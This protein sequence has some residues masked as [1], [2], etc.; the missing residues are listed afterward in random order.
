M[1]D[2]TKPTQPLSKRP[3]SESHITRKIRQQHLATVPEERKDSASPEPDS[4]GREP[5]PS[6]S[7]D[8][9]QESTSH[10]ES[11]NSTKV[12]DREASA[13]PTLSNFP[14]VESIDCA[15]L[16]SHTFTAGLPP[17]DLL[18]RTSG[19]ERLSVFML[20]QCHQHTSV[21]FLDCLWP[22]F[23]LWHF[24]PVL[25]EWQWRTRKGEEGSKFRARRVKYI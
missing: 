8:P 7:A 1:E 6:P 14:D 2:Y 5:S 25:V 17:L 24:L 4:I 23:D 10:A 16:D 9:S 15:T 22:E 12:D 18:V 21:V 13:A 20:W 19:V 11:S 3:F